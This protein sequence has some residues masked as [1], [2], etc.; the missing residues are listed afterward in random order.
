M[1]V[2]IVARGRGIHDLCRKRI[3]LTGI[4]ITVE[5]RSNLHL[6]VVVILLNET[7]D[8]GAF[9]SRVVELRIGA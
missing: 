6:I 4:E 7:S 5:L 3:A 2:H 9:S 1:Q 8:K